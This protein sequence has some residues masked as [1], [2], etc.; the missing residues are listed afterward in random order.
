MNAN[1]FDLLARSLTS[2]SSRRGMTRALAGLTLGGMLAPLFGMSSGEARKKRKKNK[3]KKKRGSQEGCL[4]DGSRCS[5][6][7]RK[8]TAD[9]CLQVPFTIEARWSNGASDH[10]HCL[11]VPNAPG[12]ALPSPYVRFCRGADTNAGTLYPF[13]YSSGD[14][15]GPGDEVMTVVMLLDGTYEFWVELDGP[16]SI[17]ELTVTLR[18]GDGRVVRAWSSPA[19]T[20]TSLQKGWHVFD[21]EGSGRSITA[22][23][24]LI[25]RIFSGPHAQV[26]NACP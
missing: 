2:R 21:I 19:N 5:S 14:A 7:G 13:A 4:P 26:T 17:G 1:R 23:D 25:D 6:T 9:N 24:T 20:S 15:Q 16:S 8:C 22:V 12:A 3:P 18:N 11:F 10:D